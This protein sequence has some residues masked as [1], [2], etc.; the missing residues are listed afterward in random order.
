MLTAASLEHCRSRKQNGSECQTAAWPYSA[1]HVMDPYDDTVDRADVQNEYCW[2]D[3]ILAELLIYCKLT[4]G[5]R[6][7]QVL[8]NQLKDRSTGFPSIPH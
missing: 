7:T 8:V 2:K 5:N 3:T 6:E 1:L 4:Q